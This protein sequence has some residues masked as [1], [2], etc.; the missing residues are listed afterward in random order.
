MS[1]EK[2]QSEFA[3][4]LTDIKQSIER[5]LQELLESPSRNEVLSV[6]NEGIVDAD[7]QGLNMI[8][9]ITRVIFPALNRTDQVKNILFFI[10]KMPFE[11]LARL[12][13]NE[14]TLA[15]LELEEALEV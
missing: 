1:K 12:P 5:A 6:F 7:P 2:S 10:L 8:E 13:L 9:F 15:L 3:T 11:E 4:E 14:N